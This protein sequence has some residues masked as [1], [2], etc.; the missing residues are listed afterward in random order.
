MFPPTSA[1]YCTSCSHYTFGSTNETAPLPH[2]TKGLMKP[3][4]PDGLLYIYMPVETLAD[5][6]R[7][8]AYKRLEIRCH[9][10]LSQWSHYQRDRK[11][12]SMHIAKM[13]QS[14]KAGKVWSQRGWVR[15]MQSYC[16][17][18]RARQATCGTNIP[19]LGWLEGPL[20][21]YLKHFSD[22][23]NELI[24]HRTSRAPTPVLQPPRLSTVHV[25]RMN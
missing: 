10:T 6:S 21:L 12:N 11:E 1:I 22:E 20:I 17:A 8:N 19:L 5:V 18:K 9:G 2:A 16:L 25:Y 15:K 3:S 7:P 4:L 14:T 24:H 13:R 23:D